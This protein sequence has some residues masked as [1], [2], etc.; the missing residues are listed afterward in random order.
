MKE[1]L[2]KVSDLTRISLHDLKKAFT[3]LKLVSLISAINSQADNENSSSDIYID[4]PV[5][6]K[7]KI[8]EDMDFDFIPDVDFKKDIYQI[9]QNPENF[10]IKELKKVL[11][12]TDK[13]EIK[14]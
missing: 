5:F 14:E 12:I 1:T 6:G 11:K 10:L 2:S 9:R 7:V 13:K 8:N 4:I 3:L